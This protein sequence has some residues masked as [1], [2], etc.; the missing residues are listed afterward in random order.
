MK[1]TQ[2]LVIILST[3]YTTQNNFKKLS[4]NW[5]TYQ[6]STPTMKLL[7]DFRST[8]HLTENL[9]NFIEH[10]EKVAII[11]D[12]VEVNLHIKDLNNGR[13]PSAELRNV[14]AVKNGHVVE[15][16]D[17]VYEDNTALFI[18]NKQAVTLGTNI[19]DFKTKVSLGSRFDIY[20]ELAETLQLLHKKNVLH[21]NVNP[22][23]LHTDSDYNNFKL[24]SFENSSNLGMATSRTNDY[25]TE[26]PEKRAN[27]QLPGNVNM[28]L[29][30]LAMTICQIEIGENRFKGYFGNNFNPNNYSGVISKI[31]T[32][33][34]RLF[35]KKNDNTNL[36]GRAFKSVLNFDSKDQIYQFSHLIEYMLSAN[37][38]SRLSEEDVIEKLKDFR[39]LFKAVN[40]LNGQKR[41]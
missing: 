19:D 40:K 18:Y 30:S 5:V 41:I 13:D 33:L 27:S 22:N 2:L 11:Y 17:T 32:D 4:Q 29:W 31:K 28:D 37:P 23:A 10:P 16:L 3:L 15:L 39:Y 14:Q 35:D 21:G 9:Q 36:F 34:D 8:K 26:A 20:V 25:Y 24:S 1:I 6:T 7:Q 12:V 38:A